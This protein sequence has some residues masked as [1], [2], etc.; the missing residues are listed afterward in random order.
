MSCPEARPTTYPALLRNRSFHSFLWMQF[1]AA[2][3][4]NVY[5]M[6]VS[7]GAVEFAPGRVMGARYLAVAGAVFVV[8]FILFAGYAGQMADR[9]SKT[10]VLQVTKSCEI[11]IM[12]AGAWALTARSLY[13]L[14]AVLFLLAL[15]ANMF[16]PA[17]YGIVPEMLDDAALSRANGLL[18]FSTFA[19]I[20]LGSS[21]GSFLFARWNSQPLRMGGVL[22]AI[23]VA[24]SI[25]SLFIRR[26]PASGAQARFNPNPFAEVWQG[27]RGI[28]RSR[29]LLL[30][31]AGNTYFWL[32]GGLVQLAVILLGHES[33][34]LSGA[35]TGLLIAAL[36]AGIG[37]GSIAAGSLSGG[38]IELGLIPFGALLLSVSSIAVGLAHSFGYCAIALAAVGF[39]GGLFAVPL[40]AWLQ[41]AANP[42][43]KG[44]LLA[45]NGFW[46]SIG[47]V[48]ASALL[49]SLH[50]LFHMT[51]SQ[52][53]IGLGILTMLVL[54]FA[55]RLLA[56]PM[57]R[58]AA[59]WIVRI[60][61][62]IKVVGVHHLPKTG[63]AVIVSNHVSYSDAVLISCICPRL[64]RFLMFEPLY[65]NRFLG[66]VCRLF[67]TI[68][69]APGSP[70]AAC[71]AL[72]SAQT[73]LAEG[74]MVAIFPEGQL[75]D[76][77][78]VQ[79]FERGVEM[80]ARGREGTPIVPV[81]LEGLW[82]HTSSR[83]GGRAFR[84]LPRLR[85]RVTIVIGEPLFAAS[86]E[87]MRAQV[88]ELGT[89]AASEHRPE[90]ATLGHRFIQQ[91]K[92]NWHEPAIADS[93]GDRMTWGETLVN[94][95][96]MS[97]A[98]RGEMVG[99]LAAPSIEGV[100]SNL[101]VTLAGKAAVNLNFSAGPDQI[102]RAIEIARVNTV[103][104]SR[105]LA[106]KLDLDPS[107]RVVLIDELL[108]RVTTRRRLLTS[109]ACRLLPARLLAPRVNSDDVAAVIFSSGSTGTPK[110]VMLSHWNLIA[111]T[112]AAAQIYP[113]QKGDG[114]LGVL[115]FFHSFGYAYTIWFPLLYGYRCVYHANPTDARVIGDLAARHKPAFFLSTPTFCQAY[116]RRCT[117][118]QFSTIRC[119]AVGAEKL[120]P[121]L[122]AAFEDKF[123]IHLLEGYGCTEM[124]PV[125]SA[126]TPNSR[127][128]GAAGRLLPNVSARI[129]NPETFEALEPGSTGL[130]LVNS[131]ARMRGYTGD[132][133]LTA[134]AL[135]DNWYITGDLAFIDEEGFLH[136]VDRLARFSKI[137][138]EMVPHG[139]IEDALAGIAGGGRIA[140]T[141][142]PDE[143]RGER[144][145]VVY[146]NPDVTPDA[147]IDHLRRAGLPALW[148]PKSDSFCRVES[149]PVLGAGKTDLKKVRELAMTLEA[150][151]V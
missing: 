65:R 113:L 20:V 130:L 66:P 89:L 29:S 57:L 82:G 38:N 44:R 128:S 49:W 19:A 73:A 34:H 43:E 119:F 122:A 51:P 71:R 1:L 8:P 26:V 59:S 120:R 108:A 92:R 2:F 17:K 95:A 99:I 110:G 46:N 105:E 68:P 139:K 27:S 33:L 93:T 101:A 86:A 80:I 78:H 142:I 135:H 149:I 94:A 138:G 40:N 137:G 32:A 85:H 126:S 37:A 63:G 140:V 129:V 70:R 55:I 147:M 13:S 25:A 77:G 107:V 41:H 125:I 54:A 52:I 117:R 143:R 39:A 97:S 74:D 148:I 36:A 96:L 18:E 75:T 50:D 23:A 133:V 6:I 22:L 12:L 79:S 67:R 91:A 150:V 16:S 48:I 132:P 61:F 88:L 58:F 102:A 100:V 69:V 134:Q 72:C 83:K 115:P 116:L 146:A 3:N 24:G 9:F 11:V 144:L 5:K 15:Q 111:N 84:S 21:A 14:L 62:R 30:A 64:V 131:P 109:L 60:F 118:E 123:G 47:I 28:L 114:I 90:D 121:A 104:A 106:L 42:Q 81:Y 151:I 98:V 53:F 112:S 56:A 76:S 124:G 45:T 145:A 141:G 127:K 87:Q 31:V 10:R 35:K 4:D 136:I 103:L 7:M